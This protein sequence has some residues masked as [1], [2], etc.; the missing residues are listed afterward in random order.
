MEDKSGFPQFSLPNSLDSDVIDESTGRRLGKQVLRGVTLGATG[1][2]PQTIP[3]HIAEFVGEA[4]PFSVGSAL[5]GPAVAPIAAVL[6]IPKLAAQLLRAGVMGAG[7][8]GTRAAVGGTDEGVLKSAAKGAALFPAFE[9]GLRGVAKAYRYLI[10]KSAPQVATKIADEVSAAVTGVEK[11]IIRPVVTPQ[12]TG[13]LQ[14][15]L[16]LDLTRQGTEQL[17]LDLGQTLGIQPT[18]RVYRSVKGRFVGLKDSLTNFVV[19]HDPDTGLGTIRPLTPGAE[20]AVAKVFEAKSQQLALGFPEQLEL[21]PPD[22]EHYLTQLISSE[23]RGRKELE[24]FAR[25]RTPKDDYLKPFVKTTEIRNST[26]VSELLKQP[27]DVLT[28]TVMEGEPSKL[29]DIAEL[30]LTSQGARTRELLQGMSIP[31]EELQ[32]AVNDIQMNVPSNLKKEA[33]LKFL[34]EKCGGL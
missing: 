23:I 3:E 31:D 32:R 22:K 7:V 21:M 19:D 16:P 28:R 11:P 8:E 26:K 1:R 25:P 10:P 30:K 5:A 14:G 9:L 2:P 4:V 20:N 17:G 18:Q 15:N 27:D 6:K 12:T 33:I 34:Q 24:S 13:P 29:A